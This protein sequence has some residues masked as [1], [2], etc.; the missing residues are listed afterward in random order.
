MCHNHQWISSFMIFSV[1]YSFIR[2]FVVQ[3][4][5]CPILTAV[6]VAPGVCIV[7]WVATVVR[8]FS[9]TTI[10]ECFVSLLLNPWYTRYVSSR[11]IDIV[12]CVCEFPHVV[13]PSWIIVVIIT[14]YNNNNAVCMDECRQTNVYIKCT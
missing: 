5:V 12:C 11:T 3:F 6:I 2:T 1:S 4:A 10:G 13:H 14:A 7:L 9:T 8:C